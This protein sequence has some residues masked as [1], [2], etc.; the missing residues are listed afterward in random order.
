MSTI[1]SGT[2][3]TSTTSSV[4]PT[5]ATTTET[6]SS[7]FSGGAY[8]LFSSTTKPD[9]DDESLV[10]HEPE[11]FSSVISRKEHPRDHASLLSLSRTTKSGGV[12][13]SIGGPS[14]ITAGS[15]TLHKVTTGLPPSSLIKPAAG[16]VSNVEV[17]AANAAKDQG[18]GHSTESD[19]EVSSL[20]A[21]VT[22]SEVSESE[23]SAANVVD[24]RIRR[25]NISSV[26]SNE[27]DSTVGPEDEADAPLPP[28]KDDDISVP[29]KSGFTSSVTD[30]ITS[31]MRYVLSTN[32]PSAPPVPMLFKNHR[33]PQPSGPLPSSDRPHI[34][35]DWV[36]GTR[37]KF[38]CT[39]YFAQQFD[40]LRRRCGIEEVFLA[41]IGKSANWN[42]EGG[43][44]KS[45]FWKTHDNRFIIK[46]LVNAWNVADL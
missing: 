36:I 21:S 42:A 22:A 46:T 28:P 9:P 8:K 25:A 24:V 13:S 29:G 12:E 43:K 20:S 40:S 18:E 33:H 2:I 41:S 26:D 23:V 44:S 45:N 16:V 5:P 19:L 4:P 31:A 17:T 38:S 39:V 35:Y 7:F 37:M 15:S 10:W 27:S 3:A 11:S 34:K 1:R 32:D 30:T 6:S 14:T